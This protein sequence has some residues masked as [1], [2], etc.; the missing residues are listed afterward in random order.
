[1]EKILTIITPVKEYCS[2][3]LLTT[4]SVIAFSSQ[5]E[6]EWIVVCPECLINEIESIDIIQKSTNIRVICEKRP[7]IY[8]AY[9][10]ALDL[11]ETNYYLPLSSGDAVLQHSADFI[12]NLLLDENYNN[13]YLM[14]FSVL[15]SRALVASSK[16][17]KCLLCVS[18]NTLDTSKILSPFLQITASIRC[19]FSIIFLCL[20]VVCFSIVFLYNYVV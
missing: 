18:L 7:S 16:T 2:D 1:M 11:V 12:R 9:N 17:I 4:H 5:I 15:T 19:S 3:F 14:F 20:H 10:T 6:I 13:K 8:G